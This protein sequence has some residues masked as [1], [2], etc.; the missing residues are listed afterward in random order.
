MNEEMQALNN[1]R[2]PQIE[3][4]VREMAMWAKALAMRVWGPEFDPGNLCETP[5]VV[6]CICNPRTPYIKMGRG[7]TQISWEIMSHLA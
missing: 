5:D 2:H 7:N 1:K 6:V 4:V 3:P